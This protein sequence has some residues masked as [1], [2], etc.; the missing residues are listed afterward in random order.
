MGRS[1]VTTQPINFLTMLNPRTG[2]VDDSEHELY[3]RSLKSKILVF[4]NAIGSSVGAYALYSL[5]TKGLAPRAIICSSVIDIITASA[6]AI[7]DIP[8][9]DMKGQP[10]ESMSIIR[11][12]T[13]VVV[14]ADSC[15]IKI[16][17]R[18]DINL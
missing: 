13:Q 1:L 11:T 4:P 18:K 5:K 3:G 16:I 6:C 8:A 12:G 2:I 10:F 9:V 17:K 7:S 14:D 15:H